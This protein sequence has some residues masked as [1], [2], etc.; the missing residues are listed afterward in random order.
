M[1]KDSAAK[2]GTDE[3]GTKQRGDG[4][5]H[6]GT[7][8]ERGWAGDQSKLIFSSGGKKTANYKSARD[9]TEGAEA[10]KKKNSS[11]KGKGPQG[12]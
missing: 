4:K 6:R 5:K 11:I 7:L 10:K 12:N 8:R 9:C 3:K 2:K 1:E